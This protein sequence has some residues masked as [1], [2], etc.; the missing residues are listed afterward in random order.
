MSAVALSAPT[1]DPDDRGMHDVTQIAADWIDAWNS[2]DLDRILAHY[3]AGVTVRSPRAREVVPESG[4]VVH[5]RAGVESYWRTALGAAPELRFRLEQAFTTVDGL[6]ILYRNERDR[7]VIEMMTFDRD[8]HID[9]VTVA[10]EP[11]R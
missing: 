5:G 3:A 4:G 11:D 8:G 1:V 10:Y 7:R 6:A 2:H 9:N